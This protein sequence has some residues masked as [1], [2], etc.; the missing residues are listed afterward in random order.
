MNESTT[1][2]G[3]YKLQRELFA[4]LGRLKGQKNSYFLKI[5]KESSDQCQIMYPL[6]WDPL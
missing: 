5:S 1:E 3:A 4:K 6:Y 2:R